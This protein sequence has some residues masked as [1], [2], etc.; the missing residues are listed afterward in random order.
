MSSSH[1]HTAYSDSPFYGNCS[2]TEGRTD[3]RTNTRTSRVLSRLSAGNNAASSA[4]TAVVWPWDRK[5]NPVMSHPAVPDWNLFLHIM[6][7]LREQAQTCSDQAK[8]T[9]A[10]TDNVIITHSHSIQWFT[11]L[12]QLLTDRRTDGRTDTR[13][14]RVLSRLSAG[15]NIADNLASNN[16]SGSE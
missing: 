6:Q 10:M 9:F 1:I 14:S 12:W 5:W 7:Y 16:L 13:T 8:M 2:Q 11:L 3:G 15:N 4:R